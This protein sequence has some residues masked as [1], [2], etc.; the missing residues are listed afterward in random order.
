[1][2]ALP[3]LGLGVGDNGHRQRGD[4]ILLRA[5]P[6]R[7][8]DRLGSVVQNMRPWRAGGPSRADGFTRQQILEWHAR[9]TTLSDIVG[10]AASVGI[11]KTPQGTPR[12]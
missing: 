6:F 7:G 1:L 9:R 3:T 8:S 2:F 4:T 5:L 10:V 12:L 11:V